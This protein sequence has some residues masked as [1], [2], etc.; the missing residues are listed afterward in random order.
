M[1]ILT[2]FLASGFIRRL[3]SSNPVGYPSRFGMGGIGKRDRRHFP[4]GERCTGD[5]LDLDDSGRR[6]YR[7]QPASCRRSSANRAS[8]CIDSGDGAFSGGAAGACCKSP[9]GLNIAAVLLMLMGT[10]WYLLFNVIAGAAAIP[11]DLRL[12]DG[13]APSFIARPLADFDPAALFPYIITGAITASG[14]A[15][16]A[17]IVANTSNSAAK[18]TRRWESA[19]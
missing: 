2:C 18:P 16:N 4:P 17:S 19:R 12:H 5:Y 7:N 15:W 14:G 6:V 9:G 1:G 11:Q 13:S 10:Q 3:S 8:R